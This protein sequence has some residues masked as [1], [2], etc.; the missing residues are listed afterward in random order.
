MRYYRLARINE[1]P[2]S[3]YALEHTRRVDDVGISGKDVF[4]VYV[5]DAKEALVF[6][7]LTLGVVRQGLVDGSPMLKNIAYCHN[8]TKIRY[9]LF[10]CRLRRF[11]FLLHQFLQ[12]HV[13]VSL[14]LV[15]HN[16]LKHSCPGSTVAGALIFEYA[17]ELN[18]AVHGGELVGEVGVHVAEDVAVEIRGE[19]DAHDKYGESPHHLCH[20][21]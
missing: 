6:K 17:D 8:A 20:L 16:L 5:A 7:T 11:L 15:C 4:E 14:G 2:R 21:L 19:A 1:F 13:E 10:F 18:E 3:Y 12:L 9:C